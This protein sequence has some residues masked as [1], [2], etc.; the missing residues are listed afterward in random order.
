VSKNPIA[1]KMRSI[2]EWWIMPIVN[3]DG[4]VNG[5]YRCN[6]QGKDM[7]RHFFA[8]HDD[9]ADKIGR[10]IEVEL[11]RDYLKNQI[12]AGETNPLKLF[13]DIHAHSKDASIFSYAPVPENAWDVMETKRWS[14]ILDSMSPYFKLENCTFKNEKYKR[15]CARLGIFRDFELTNSYTIETSCYG[16]EV[17]KPYKE[18]ENV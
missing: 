13:L 16:Y 2:F 5:N 18:Q 12:P 3:P 9:E 10:C 4:V 15:N 8:N 14:E 17:K 6:C 11:I 7:N 1:N